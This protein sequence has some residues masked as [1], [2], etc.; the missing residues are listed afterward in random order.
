MLIEDPGALTAK[1]DSIVGVVE[2]EL[3][4]G[5][6]EMVLIAGKGGMVERRRW[7]RGG[8]KLWQGCTYFA[9]IMSSSSV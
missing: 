9:F 7:V 4:L 3:F 5:M 2:H 8:V 6:A 1:L